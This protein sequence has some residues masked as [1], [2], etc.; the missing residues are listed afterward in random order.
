MS[1]PLFSELIEEMSV[2]SKNSDTEEHTLKLNKRRLGM[3]GPAF[4]KSM[5]SVNV[6][7]VSKEL[8]IPKEQN[9]VETC[10]SEGKQVVQKY[11]CKKC[12]EMFFTKTDTND[13]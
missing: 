3:T 4:M 5:L 10:L 8:K 13:I 7:D 6:S 9:V 11:M 12:P 1:A 2:V